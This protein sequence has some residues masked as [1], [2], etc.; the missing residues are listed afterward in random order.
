LAQRLSIPVIDTT[1]FFDGYYLRDIYQNDNTHFNG[2]GYYIL[3]AKAASVL[4]GIANITEPYKIK[5]HRHLTPE[6]NYN[7]L[8]IKNDVTFGGASDSPFGTGNQ[9]GEGIFAKIN[10]NSQLNF[11]FYADEDDLLIIPQFRSTDGGQCSIE[12]NYRATTP[13]P[14]TSLITGSLDQSQQVAPNS[15]LYFSINQGQI[16]DYPYISKNDLIYNSLR[17]TSRGFNS[18]QVKNVSGTG[19][20]WFYGFYVVN[21]ADYITDHLIKSRG[22]TVSI[23][24]PEVDILDILVKENIFVHGLLLPNTDSGEKD[25]GAYWKKWQKGYFNGFVS[26][27]AFSTTNRPNYI[28]YQP[29]AMIFDTTL[30]KPVWRNAANNGFVDA[31][32]NPV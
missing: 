16:L 20:I 13:N 30:N 9:H 21:M 1:Y 7:H 15:G 24:D 26:T 19:T 5:S 11:G 31:N 8:S 25:I 29:G 23:G 3:G 2:T 17:I 22:N 27:G 18:V 28:D 32:G 12:L 6:Q 4:T 10:A 14:I